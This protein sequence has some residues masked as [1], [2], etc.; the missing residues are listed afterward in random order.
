MA[1]GHSLSR[2][3]IQHHK[4]RVARIALWALGLF[5]NLIEVRDKS[6]FA[7]DQDTANIFGVF[8]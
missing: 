4:E 5:A 1:D 2:T 7:R 8:G 6:K 3:L